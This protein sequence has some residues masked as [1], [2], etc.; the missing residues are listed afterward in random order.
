MRL[1]KY[2]LSFLPSKLPVGMQA[3]L[4]F[5]DSIVDLSGEFADRKSMKW[6]IATMIMHLGPQRDRI[7]KQ[8]FVKSLRKTAANQVAQ[9][10]MIQLKEEQKAAELAAKEAAEKQSADTASQES[11]TNGAETKEV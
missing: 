7:S 11:P 8:Y 9:A 3:F 2:L 1:V 5:G 6:A 10:Y 4:D